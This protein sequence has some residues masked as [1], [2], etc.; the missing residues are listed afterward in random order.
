MTAMAKARPS[1]ENATAVD[2]VVD[3]LTETVPGTNLPAHEITSVV[4]ACLGLLTDDRATTNRLETIQRLA[5]RWA[6]AGMTYE[7]AQRLVHT[8]FRVHVSGRDRPDTQRLIE[9]VH[10]AT[11]AVSAGF[12]DTAGYHRDQGG[13]GELARALFAERGVA[14]IGHRHGL[15]V[16][17]RCVVLA[18]SAGPGEL[19]PVSPAELHQW[20]T[21]LCR[22]PVPAVLGGHGGTMLVPEPGVLGEI[23]AVV[24]DSTLAVVS[25]A[26]AREEIVAARRQAHELLEVVNTV[27]GTPG[28]YPFADYALEHQL[29]RSGP[30]RDR[31]ADLIAPVAA[32]PDLLVTLRTHLRSGLHRGVTA[33]TLYIHANTVDHRLKRIAELTGLDILD[34]ATM[35]QLDAALVVHDFLHPDQAVRGWRPVRRR[36][37]RGRT[38]RA[39]A[40]LAEPADI[41]A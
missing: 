1:G 38:H 34:S 41:P 25:L 11:S 21:R 10:S 13:P 3:V 8:V 5:A 6:C 16:P 32:H 36:P 40:H 19:G 26:A 37:V 2:R 9:A 30:G 33:R 28:M 27:Y 7:F 14:E 12:A 29:T 23:G 31:L 17:Q 24:E 20:I 18:V 35:W 39:A 22:R 15:P 4:T